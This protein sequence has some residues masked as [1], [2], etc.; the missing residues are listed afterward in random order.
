LSG[1]DASFQILSIPKA[2]EARQAFDFA[3]IAKGDWLAAKVLYQKRLYAQAVYMLQQ[4]VEKSA[5]SFGL[6]MGILKPSDVIKAVSHRSVYALLIRMDMFTEQLR[7][8]VTFL[9]TSDQSEVE[10]L[11]SLGFDQVFDKLTPIVPTSEMVES[12]KQ[13]IDKLN[14]SD[15]WQAT[16]T[17]DT[18]NDYVRS[19]LQQ[20][21][22]IQWDKQRVLL[23][24]QAIVVLSK[25]MKKNSD[26]IKYFL[27]ILRASPRV[28]PL[29]ML[30]MWHETP[31]R[32]PPIC[33][34]DYW[35]IREYTSDKPLIKRFP[36]L[37]KHAK[38]LANSVANGALAA[39]HQVK[40]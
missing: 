36:F 4:S 23:P 30:T 8:T 29:S 5:K 14:D 24:I 19:A 28:Y 16:L 17:L 2:Q 25:I 1:K 6:M 3:E 38:I 7:E 15:M 10:A 22:N 33:D 21:D 13:Q 20:L 40:E 37:L 9:R 35:E 11:R 31:T 32:Y 27:N 18:T 34:R 12:D 39:K 26:E